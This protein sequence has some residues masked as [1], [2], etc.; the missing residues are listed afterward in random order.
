MT[1][2]SDEFG[3]PQV[4][5]QWCSKPTPMLGT[6]ECDRCHEL[7]VRVERDKGLAWRMLGLRPQ[8]ATFA[9]AMEAKLR[10]HDAEKGMRGWRRAHPNELVGQLSYYYPDD[11]G[12]VRALWAA[13]ERWE[14]YAKRVHPIEPNAT[15]A[16]ASVLALATDVANF[17]MMI[18][19]VTGGL[20][21][22]GTEA[23]KEKS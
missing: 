6:K 11:P 1:F 13:I 10:E 16:R 7:C 12:K 23:E 22:P 15:M 8:V 21:E 17:C 18:A 2:P 20:V 5:C 3:R 4:P 9:L 19:D 14:V